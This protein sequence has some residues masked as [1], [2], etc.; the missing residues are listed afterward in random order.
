MC[1]LL[2]RVTAAVS[3]NACR[4]SAPRRIIVM[5][6]HALIPVILHICF[7][8]ARPAPVALQGILPWLVVTSYLCGP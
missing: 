3:W 5:K 7:V 4:D 6:A 2:L 1:Y 8:I